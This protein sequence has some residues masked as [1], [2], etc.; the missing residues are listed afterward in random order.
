VV[1]KMRPKP[2]PKCQFCG[3]SAMLA[4]AAAECDETPRPAKKSPVPGLPGRGFSCSYG[5]RSLVRLATT[6]S[7]GHRRGTAGRDRAEKNA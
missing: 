3:I 4:Q 1:A 2:P 6:R 7:S 5:C